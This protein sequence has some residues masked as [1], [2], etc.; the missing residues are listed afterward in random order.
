[1]LNKLR[2]IMWPQKFLMGIMMINVTSGQLA[3]YCMSY[4][5]DFLPFM[6]KTRKKFLWKLNMQP[7]SLKVIIKKL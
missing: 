7:F 1:M 6:E 2:L 4:F 3:L 5:V